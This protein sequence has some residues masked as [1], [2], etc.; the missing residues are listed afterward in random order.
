MI[1]FLHQSALQLNQFSDHEELKSEKLAVL[2]PD[3]SVGLSKKDKSMWSP[4]RPTSRPPRS[5]RSSHFR[6]A[7]SG[8]PPRQA[9]IS[10]SGIDSKS[11]NSAFADADDDSSCDD[12]YVS[13]S[14]KKESLFEESPRILKET[15]RVT[16]TPSRRSPGL[17]RK[18]EFR[19]HTI[20][21][22]ESSGIL[23]KLKSDINSLDIIRNSSYAE[24]IST[25]FSGSVFDFD[26]E[27]NSITA[28]SIASTVPSVIERSRSV[29]RSFRREDMR[30]PFAVD[31]IRQRHGS[32][33]LD[34]REGHSLRGH[35]SGAASV[36]SRRDMSRK[37]NE[38]REK[39]QKEKQEMQN[40]SMVGRNKAHSQEQLSEKDEKISKLQETIRGLKREVVMEKDENERSSATLS[41]LKFQLNECK[42]KEAETKNALREVMKN[43]EHERSVREKEMHLASKVQRAEVLMLE[44]RLTELEKDTIAKSD[45]LKDEIAKK[46]SVINGLRQDI[47]QLQSKLD[48]TSKSKADSDKTLRSQIERLELRLDNETVTHRKK[49]TEL[50]EMHQ[51]SEEEWAEKLNHMETKIEEQNARE[52]EWTDELSMTKLELENLRAYSVT[53][54]KQN[55]YLK[56]SEDDAQRLERE[57]NELKQQNSQT[58]QTIDDLRKELE[59]AQEAKVSL[60]RQ[61]ETLKVTEREKDEY[62]DKMEDSLEE[63]DDDKQG[64]TVKIEQLQKELCQ[65]QSQFQE[66][67]VTLEEAKKETADAKLQ[68]QDATSKLEKSMDDGRRLA[69]QVTEKE[70]ENEKMVKAVSS[71]ET[72]L[73]QEVEEHCADMTN[74]QKHLNKLEVKINEMQREIQTN[75]KQ[76]A[77]IPKLDT[78]I[79]ELTESL[80]QSEDKHSTLQ[81]KLKNTISKL[82]ESEINYDRLDKKYKA[83]MR[84]QSEFEEREK[85]HASNATKREREQ[86]ETIQK[87]KKEK[88]DQTAH[89][90]RLQEEV[91]KAKR[92][93]SQAKEETK[94]CKDQLKTALQSLDEMMK[95]ID[96]M[97]DE[98]DDMIKALESETEGLMKR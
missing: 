26:D 83:L 16:N 7:S 86:I 55:Q 98:S 34:G 79:K 46:S 21:R 69:K 91:V 72:K 30:G 73:K 58:E 56:N 43:V 13:M 4:D 68:L 61:L 75:Q 78:K 29:D 11:F 95:Y 53:L 14:S 85:S 27:N 48:S 66:M 57:C 19:P 62:I 17:P 44:E 42:E 87:L 1:L 18:K 81:S 5:T 37:H 97:K 31:A 51:S 82:D 22:A 3:R 47:R 12:T 28:K 89:I 54:E 8:T 40:Q 15:T 36:G 96:G 35:T 23:D 63:L 64:F 45:T 76:L 65:S 2:L 92:E 52:A 59:V 10:T 67:K 6:S 94:K 88:N 60:A 32:S 41:D 74:H 90:E 20:S 39:L 50:N 70:S 9:S 71:L 77:K 93:V 24:E 84:E 49:V 38:L 80:A 33:S 25:V